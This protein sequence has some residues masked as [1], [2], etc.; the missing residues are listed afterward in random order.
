MMPPLPVTTA[1]RRL[2]MRGF[3]GEIPFKH[4]PLVQADEGG[5]GSHVRELV[6]SG[7]LA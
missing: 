1:L 7:V 4:G 5:I 6:S 2:P 3:I